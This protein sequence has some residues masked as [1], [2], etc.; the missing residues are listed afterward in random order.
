MKRP[1]SSQMRSW[2]NNPEMWITIS[3]LYNDSD[4]YCEGSI[5]TQVWWLV[6]GS[7]VRGCVSSDVT[8]ARLDAAVSFSNQ[9]VC[10]DISNRI[11]N[12]HTHVCVSVMCRKNNFFPPVR[13]F[14]RKHFGK[15][16]HTSFPLSTENALGSSGH[17]SGFLSPRCAGS[18]SC[19]WRW[20]VADM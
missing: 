19:L 12:T 20:R 11:Y 10:W 17:L 15:E 5:V 6:L 13:T 18:S 2:D 9:L 14:A 16:K 1:V 7:Y 4:V 3:C 8:T